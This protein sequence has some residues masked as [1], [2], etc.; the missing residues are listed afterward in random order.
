MLIISSSV[1]GTTCF[2]YSLYF[3][4]CSG[5][6]VSDAVLS[7]FSDK[8]FIKFGS[9]LRRKR[10]L[11]SFHLTFPNRSFV[12]SSLDRKVLSVSEKMI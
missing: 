4:I 5:V 1:Y 7:P 11:L 8:I 2:K 6:S 10:N 9:F 3:S 12:S